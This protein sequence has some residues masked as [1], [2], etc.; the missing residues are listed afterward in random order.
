[1]G[2][3]KKKKVS[4]IYGISRKDFEEQTLRLERKLEMDKKAQAGEKVE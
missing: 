4:S 1:M 2:N 3:C